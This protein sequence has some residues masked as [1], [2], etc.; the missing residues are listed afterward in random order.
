MHHTTTPA[1]DAVNFL[2]HGFCY[3]WDWKLL[4][5]HVVADGLIGIAYVVISAALVY[6]VYRAR[7]EIPFSAMFI[8]FGVFIVACGM[9]H[10]VEILTLWRPAYWFAGLVKAITAIASVVTAAVMPRVVPVALRAVH[11]AHI[12]GERR[13]RLAAALEANEAKSQ[14]MATMSHELRTPL[15]AIV[16]YTDL[17]ENQIA[18]PITDKQRQFLGRLRASAAHLLGLITQ[19]L[20]F[21][22][23]EAGRDPIDLERVDIAQVLRESATL[24][25]P[26]AEQK[27]ITLITSIH[28]GQLFVTD[29]LK[30]R[31]IAL[32]LL[33]NAV[34]YT[35]QGQVSMR[36][37]VDPTL[38]ALHIDVRDT[39]IGI[40]ADDQQRIFDPFWQADQRMTRRVGGTGL[41]LS[42]VDRFTRALGGVVQVESEPAKGTRFVVMIPGGNLPEPIAPRELRSTPVNPVLGIA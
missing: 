33:S 13:I 8:A 12:A 9:T 29:P 28:G 31:Q 19:V 7:R 26:A 11:E 37:T 5:L 40:A 34:K 41:G 32:N 1:Q 21:E 16:G 15:N 4:T 22:R 14:F 23:I 39:G 20:D 3:L 38:N 42:I 35:D 18:G 25:A 17:L 30:V 27:G 36:A 2:P 10:F 24:L 6:L